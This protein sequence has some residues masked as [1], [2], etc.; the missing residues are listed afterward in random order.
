MKNRKVTHFIRKSTQ[1]KASFIQNQILNHLNYTPSVVYKNRTEK[2]DGG[3][4]E[5]NNTDIDI[6]NLNEYPCI[7]SKLKY[8]FLK[9]IT[10][11]DKERIIEFTKDSDILHFHYG[12]DAG[13][14]LPLLININ[15]PKVISFY[16]YDSSGFPKRFFGYGK[17]YLQKRVFRYADKV[18]AM[19]PDMKK[20]LVCIGCP[21]NKIIVHY[22]GSDTSKFYEKH[23][24]KKTDKVNFIIIS[25][26]EPQKGHKFLLEAFSNA[27]EI[28][29]N[30]KLI[31]VGKGAL[32][33]EIKKQIREENMT[34]FVSL[35]ESTVYASKEHKQYFKNSD[36]FIHPSV[37]DIN[38]DKEGIPGAIIEAMSAGLPVI[39]TYHAGIPNIIKNNKTGFLVNEWDVEN[40][41]EKILLVANNYNLRKEIGEAGQE[42]ATNNL[43][44]KNKEKELENI[45]QSLI[46]HEA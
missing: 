12:T 20:D 32:R 43:D 5:F 26:L 27:W 4:G 38:G 42:Y 15:K 40:L 10:L 24:Y 11:K 33:N 34:S 13:I 2:D 46:R 17:Y 30:I 8:E 1:L 19:S 9:L 39:S 37:T 41:K 31:I 45:Y 25:G 28:N 3:F 14:Y 36:V 16:G 21:E 23:N 29:N 44:L 35:K 22:Y 7:Y 18:F 6:L